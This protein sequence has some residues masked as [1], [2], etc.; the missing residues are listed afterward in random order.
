MTASDA[1]QVKHLSGDLALRVGQYS[2]A[3]RKAENEDA[4]GIRI[5]DGNLLTTKGAVAII[6]D[7]VSA[8][9][10]GKEA[11][12]TSVTNFLSD[13]FSTPESW[14][15]KK[16]AQQVLTALNR[17]LYSRGR[18]FADNTR[19]FVTTF[20]ALV[21]KSQQAHLFHAGDSRIYQMR[22]GSLEQITD[23]HTTR[24]SEKHSY[25]S[26]AL[27]LD[28][29]LE[30]DYRSLSIETNDLYLL[31]TDGIHD[32]LG[33]DRMEYMLRELTAD[34][35][36]DLACKALAD[37]AFAAG[38][39]DNLS[40]QLIRVDQLPAAGIDDVVK[41]LTELS[42]PPFLEEGM[43]L[44][45]YR[46]VR[47][48][49]ASNRS[50]I[51]QVE[52]VESGAQFCMKTPSVNFDDDPAYIE[53]FVLE[54]WIGN[55]INSP[56]V[57]KVV[58]TDRPKSCLYY[59]TEYIPSIT[60]SRWMLEHPRPAVEEAVYLIDQIAK[61]IRAFH[62]RET[63]HQD[64]KPDNILI[65]RNGQ[66]K[67]IDFGSCH[68]AGLSEIETA[69]TRDIALGT[70]QYSAPEYTVGR[71][72]NYQADQFSLAVISYEMLTSEL[73][74]SGKL[75][76]CKSPR[77]FLNTHYTESYRINPLVPHWIDG[78]LRKS[79]RY[80]PERRHADVM[81]F[82]YELKHPNPLYLEYRQRPLMDRDPVRAWKLIAGILALSQ[83]ATFMLLFS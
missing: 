40:C 19:G 52:D 45:G 83:L 25:L 42:F 54:S 5:P 67:I 37:A 23:D 6:A 60:L 9:E 59:L 11:S 24:V 21:L 36:L 50:Q 13:Y 74:F 49:H 29:H 12:Q 41:R 34:L 20:S 81:E 78:A 69:I 57:I 14:S 31:T 48:L 38:S 76:N 55:R 18:S 77:D 7:G 70:A 66:V 71:K 73:P 58:E 47:E 8:A 28:V 39:K 32:V 64:I 79:L 65:D 82:A 26:R 75:E 2:A 44:D 17:W 15:V 72:P 22:N 10:A 4:I 16:S 35:D 46:V 1:S 3:G 56:Y 51:Y 68:A 30:M 43:I 27:G 80:Q 61:G 53:R 33:R 63:L 62:R